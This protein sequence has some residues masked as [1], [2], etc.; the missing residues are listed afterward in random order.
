MSQDWWFSVVAIL[1]ALTGQPGDTRAQV[2][3]Q[4]E[5][6]D[7]RERQPTGDGLSPVEEMPTLDRKQSFTDVATAQTLLRLV[8]SVL[9][10]K[11]EPIKLWLAGRSRCRVLLW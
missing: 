5:T 6:T 1:Q 4:A 7:W 3:E 11:A 8:Q 2:L 10:P 9:S